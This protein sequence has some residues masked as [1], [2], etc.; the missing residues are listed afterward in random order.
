MM[1]TNDVE[2]TGHISDDE[3]KHIRT[4]RV[5]FL[6]ISNRTTYF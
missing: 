1:D 6:E 3:I 2:R 4:W 5:V